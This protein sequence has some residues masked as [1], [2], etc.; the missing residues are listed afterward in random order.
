MED[1][2]F[3]TQQQNYVT[4]DSVAAYMARVMGWMSLGLLV[5]IISAIAVLFVRPLTMFVYGTAFGFWAIYIA[6]FILVLSISASIHKVQPST[7]TAMF[8]VYSVLT[9][10]TISTTFILYN[11]VSIL[12]AFLMAGVVFFSMALYGFITKKDL[13]KIGRL[14][15]FALIGIIISSLINL[16]IGNGPIDIIISV[17]TIVVFIGLTAYDTQKTK[18]FYLAAVNAGHDPKGGVE[19]RLAIIGALQLYLDF[20]NL[21]LRILR[22]FGRRRD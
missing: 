13:T 22:I 11:A 14:A 15:M 6:Q 18:G 8:I 2:Q 10:F 3:A 5:T 12:Y 17:I 20:I 9:G 7:A 16:F 21:F 19:H 4:E 1:F